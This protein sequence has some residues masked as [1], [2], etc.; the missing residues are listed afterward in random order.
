MPLEMVFFPFD[1][2][3]CVEARIIEPGC[4]KIIEDLSDGERRAIGIYCDSKDEGGTVFMLPHEGLPDMEPECGTVEGDLPEPYDIFN[5]KN[6]DVF[7]KLPVVTRDA[8][9]GR[10]AVY[11]VASNVLTRYLNVPELMAYRN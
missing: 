4:A 6:G 11:H 2:E 9:L 7:N 8:V 5:I 10:L 3:Y 1:D